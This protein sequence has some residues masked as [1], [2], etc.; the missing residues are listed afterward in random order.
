MTEQFYKFKDELNQK[1]VY[2]TKQK[3]LI[4]DL[5]NQFLK[6]HD[7]LYD[8]IPYYDFMIDLELTSE[9]IDLLDIPAKELKQ[10]GQPRKDSK[11]MKTL[12]QKYYDYLE[13]HDIDITI[14]PDRELSLKLMSLYEIGSSIR[15]GYSNKSF[16]HNDTFYYNGSPL[17]DHDDI[18]TIDGLEYYQ[19]LN[20]EKE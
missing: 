7:L 19:A 17:I 6:E 1:M 13:Q 11:T 2:L 18:I 16:I 20:K 15:N 3:Q 4:R 10:N 9:Q 8:G 14:K 5:R 12:K